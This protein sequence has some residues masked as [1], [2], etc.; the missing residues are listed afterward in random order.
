MDIEEKRLIDAMMRL[1]MKQ[2]YQTAA[3]HVLT[4]SHAFPSLLQKI[5]RKVTRCWF[6]STHLQPP[7]ESDFWLLSASIPKLRGNPDII[8]VMDHSL[9]TQE[10]FLCRTEH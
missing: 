9:S 5:L 1:L 7:C 8:C 3:C 4:A 10:L 6:G 2:Q